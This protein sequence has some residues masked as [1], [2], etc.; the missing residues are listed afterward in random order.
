MPAPETTNEPPQLTDAQQNQIQMLEMQ[1]P[2]LEAQL[3]AIEEVETNNNY[4]KYK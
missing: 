4:L 2:A 3:V 1:I